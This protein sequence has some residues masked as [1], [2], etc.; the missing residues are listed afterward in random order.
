MAGIFE[1]TEDDPAGSAWGPKVLGMLGI[2]RVDGFR[3]RINPA[4]QPKADVLKAQLFP[5]VLAT[6]V[7]EHGIRFI[8][9]EAIPFACSGPRY[10]YSGNTPG[11]VALV[12]GLR[13]F[14]FP[15]IQTHLKYSFKNRS[16]A[17]TLEMKGKFAANAGADH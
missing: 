15:Y 11:G 13:P 10:H 4:H 8:A 2:P 17:F 16:G 5:S 14:L 3:L 7:D 9:R 1:A 6:S 12:I